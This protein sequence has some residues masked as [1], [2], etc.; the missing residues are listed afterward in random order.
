MWKPQPIF[1]ILV[2]IVCMF[3]AGCV[4]SP[5][6]SAVTP[7]SLATTVPTPDPATPV[8]TAVETST[9]QEVVTIIHYVSPTRDIRASELLFALQ[10]PVEWNVSTTRLIRSDTPDY[11]TDLVAGNVFSIHS[12]YFS[13]D[14]DRAFRDQFRQWSPTP[15]ETTVTINGITYDRFESAGDGRTQVAY[16]V[17]MN[18][19]NERGYVNVL[20]FTARDS[21]RFEKE[22]FETVV[23]SFR[24]FGT[25]E[26]KTMPGEEI[27]LYDLSGN[28][29][30]CDPRTGRSLAWGEW[31]GDSSGD[32]SGGDSSGDDSSDDDSSTDDYPDCPYA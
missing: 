9:P 18:S 7:T 26:F 19:A 21:N 5:A 1:L 8:P 20:V 27:P 32:P 3:S 30:P 11:R 29:L 23:A 17:R 14:K 28:V 10:V 4:Q 16:I 15:T 25:D 31:E 13:P 22:D 6:N 24:Y 2:V 12:Y